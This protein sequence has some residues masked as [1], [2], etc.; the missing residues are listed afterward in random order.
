MKKIT[1]AF[2]FIFILLTQ[3]AYAQQVAPN[4]QLVDSDGVV[5][6][7]YSDYLLNG[8]TVVIKIF[9]VDCPPCNAIAPGFQQKYEDWG[10]GQGDVEFFEISNKFADLD[11][12]INQYKAMHGLTMPSV[13]SEGGGVEAAMRYMD[14]TYGPFFGTPT[15]AVVAPDGALNFPL[16]FNQ[17]DAAIE[18]T[19]ATGGTVPPSPVVVSFTTPQGI[20]FP[21]Q[22]RFLL[23]SRVDQN[24]QRDITALTSGTHNF[25][26]PS[27]NFP[28][29]ESPFITF[30]STAPAQSPQ[31]TIA[32]I[33]VLRRHI[34][35]IELLTD[36]ARIL[37][38]DVTGDNRITIND[39]L[40]L[41]RVILLLDTQFPNGTPSFQ[42]IPEERDLIIT[43][44]GTNT[45]NFTL[46]KMGNVN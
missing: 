30:E 19:G 37:A 22:T 24:Y 33:T 20:A 6:S 4:F 10:E 39:I 45:V 41:Q 36:P 34:L 28:E 43:P 32:D 21:S 26:Y 27:E 8:K 12:R 14:G 11:V 42:S 40:A 18:A 1:N 29:T 35:F 5:H 2:A 23:K 15:F 17:L 3:I 38:A 9:F 44:G 46:V 7:L 16:T 25:T 13:G 31:V